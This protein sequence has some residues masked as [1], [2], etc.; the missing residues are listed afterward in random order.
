MK[1]S[2]IIKDI[3]ISIMVV[4]SI[5]LGLGVI[6]YDKISISKIIPQSEEY[7]LTEEMN[8]AVEGGGEE[9]IEETVVQYNIDAVDLKKHEK[10]KEYN[11]GKK[12]PFAPFTDEP[13]INNTSSGNSENFYEDDGTK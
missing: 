2:K 11:K 12:Y 5:V 4:I 3:F 6:L 8:Q 13:D 1:G 10:T 7:M 9:K